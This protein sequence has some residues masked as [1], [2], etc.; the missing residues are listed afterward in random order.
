[1]LARAG[2]YLRVCGMA[3]GG[4]KGPSLEPS[5]PALPTAVNNRPR[6]NN[7]R[8][9][10]L[11]VWG[12]WGVTTR[13]CACGAPPHMGTRPPNRRPTTTAGQANRPRPTSATSATAPHQPPRRYEDTVL[14]AWGE[15]F[16][17][18]CCEAYVR[19]RAAPRCS[20]SH[21]RRTG[22][23][24]A[25]GAE[26]G[27]GPEAGPGGAFDPAAFEAALAAAR[28]LEEYVESLGMVDGGWRI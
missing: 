1:M 23:P 24:G 25:P 17:R 5:G 10:A 22:S 7:R 20:P 4:W 6:S 27:A 12:V 26:P 18:P 13:C 21:G 14:R 3:E 8:P 28:E 19:L 11:H 16:W 2:R 15:A 9:T